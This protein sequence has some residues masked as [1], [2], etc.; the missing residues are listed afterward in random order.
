MANPAGFDDPGNSPSSGSP[1]R[2][3]GLCISGW[4]VGYL[5]S[6]ASSFA[7][8]QIAHI[9]PEMEAS[10]SVVVWTAIYGVVCSVL[11]AMI[12]ASFCRRFALGIGAAIAAT[13]AAMA[14]WSWYETPT[15]AHWSQTIAVLLMAPAAQFAAIFRRSDD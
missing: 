10:T 1:A 6:A 14:M 3:I 5:V 13:T 2:T 7:Y 4:I 8:F 12:G 15:H 11:A 9:S